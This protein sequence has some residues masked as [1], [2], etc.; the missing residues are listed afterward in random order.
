MS[1]PEYV[2][3]ALIVSPFLP[4]QRSAKGGTLAKCNTMDVVRAAASQTQAGGG[5]ACGASNTLGDRAGSCYFPDL[6]PQDVCASCM[7]QHKS[8]NINPG[9][10]MTRPTMLFGQSTVAVCRLSSA[11]S[12]TPHAACCCSHRIA[13]NRPDKPSAAPPGLLQASQCSV[14]PRKCSVCATVSCKY[15]V[16]TRGGGS[17][18]AQRVLPRRG[19]LGVRLSG[20]QNAPR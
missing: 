6:P 16:S 20:G 17:K 5:R 1:A 9:A 19:Q 13:A 7:R 11:M 12:G 2:C 8:Q 15:I 10:P 4:A 14:M 3:K 18:P